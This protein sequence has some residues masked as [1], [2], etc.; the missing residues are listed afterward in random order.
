MRAVF[1]AICA[2]AALAAATVSPDSIPPCQFE[3]GSGQSVCYWDAATRGNHV[4]DS[5]VLIGGERL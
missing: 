4:G 5:Y 1:S 2:V 3:D